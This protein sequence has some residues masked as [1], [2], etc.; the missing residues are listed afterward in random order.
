MPNPFLADFKRLYSSR[1]QRLSYPSNV[2]KLQQTASNVFK[3]NKKTISN[4]LIPKH[5]DINLNKHLYC[6]IEIIIIL[7]LV[8]PFLFQVC[9]L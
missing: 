7:V 2:P 6:N 1:F 3:T 9:F 8:M 5:K 4:P